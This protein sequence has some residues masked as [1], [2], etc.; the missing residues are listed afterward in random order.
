MADKSAI[1]RRGFVGLSTQII[2]VLSLIDAS[3]LLRSLKSQ[4]VKSS[5]AERFLT[6][7]KSL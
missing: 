4:N 6:F 7:S 3:R 2:F 5:P 1:L